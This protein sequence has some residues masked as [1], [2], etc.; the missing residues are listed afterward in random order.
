MAN[1]QSNASIMNFEIVGVSLPGISLNASYYY[2]TIHE[3]F[4]STVVPHRGSRPNA[5]RPWR[6]GARAL[7]PALSGER[8]RGARRGRRADWDGRGRCAPQRSSTRQH[9]EGVTARA[10]T[11]MRA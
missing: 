2:R 6:A 3:F 10:R 8:A 9:S 11:L 7:N 4:C 5:R 1:M